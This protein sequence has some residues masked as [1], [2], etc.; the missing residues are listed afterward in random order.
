MA[1]VRLVN[2]HVE[3]ARQRALRLEALDL[4]EIPLVPQRW[5]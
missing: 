4:S 5:K 2:R 3:V 1:T